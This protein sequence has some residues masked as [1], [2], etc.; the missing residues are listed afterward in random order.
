M[1]INKSYRIKYAIIITTLFLVYG[2]IA[3]TGGYSY[4]HYLSST[5]ESINSPQWIVDIEDSKISEEGVTSYK[6]LTLNTKDSELSGATTF[7]S[8]FEIDPTRITSSIDIKFS[9][10][11]ISLNDSNIFGKFSLY[12]VRI[13]G[14]IV[15]PTRGSYLSSVILPEDE[16]MGSIDKII[17]EITAGL[18]NNNNEDVSRYKM[19]TLTVPIALIVTKR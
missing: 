3:L 19:P 10:G 9:I 16:T 5:T 14:V 8:F 1:K 2:L 17:V 13:N 11:D 4:A 6:T 12:S 15:T 7:V 18:V